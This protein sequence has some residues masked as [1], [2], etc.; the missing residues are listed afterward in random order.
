M[1]ALL[2]AVLASIM[3]LAPLAIAQN[4]PDISGSAVTIPWDDF[5]EILQKM[6]TVSPAVEPEPPV[7]YTLGRG[8]LTGKLDKESLELTTTYPL[9]VLKKGWVVCPLVG[10]SAPLADVL[11]D[12]ETAPVT[13][14][15]GMIALILKGPATHQLTMR[16]QVAA[17][18]RPGPGSVSLPL[19]P[20][21]GQVMNL[22]IGKKLAGVSIDGATMSQQGDKISAIL[23]GDN[24]TIRYTVA[25]E[26]TDEVVEVLPSKVVVENSTLVSIDEGFVRAVV[27]LAYEVRHAPVS[28]FTLRIPEG[29][30]VA[31]C[32]GASLVGWKLDEKT[33]VLIATVGFDVKGAYNLTVVLERSTKQES[34]TFPLPGVE[35][36]NV[37]R[38]RGFFAVQV[39]GGVEVTPGQQIQGL[40]MVDAKELPTG[41][42]DGA[43]NPL[44]LSFKYLRHPFQADLKVVRHETQPVLGAAIDSANYVMQVTEDGDCVT[45]AVYTVRNNRKQ[46]LQLT[47]PDQEK[48]A[49]WSSF[50]AGKPVR[51]SKTKEGKILL[52]LEKSS[53]T[54]SELASFEVEIIYYSNLG[55]EFGSLGSID[56]ALPIVDLPVSRSML[57]V[58]APTRFSYKRSD[59]S[60][61]ER[62]VAPSPLK[63]PSFGCFQSLGGVYVED[64]MDRDEEYKYKASSMTEPAAIA[65][66]S[67]E[68]GEM[69]VQQAEAEQVFRQQIRK[70]QQ[71]QDTSGALPAKFSVPQ[72]GTALRFFEL[73]SIGESSTLKLCYFTRS[74]DRAIALLALLITIALAWFSDRLLSTREGRRTGQRLFVLGAL[75]IV[76]LVA[77]GAPIAYVV[78]GAFF[79]LAARVVRWLARKFV[80]K[81]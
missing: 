14:N 65:S 43:T 27:Q 79:G 76:A 38:E 52:P 63:I 56:L 44:V 73:I 19:P 37:E 41:L 3:L 57:T 25:V 13:D 2:I 49:L 31:D 12:N 34:F 35:A 11:I 1:R 54:G 61:R 51:P 55:Q 78:H 24:L 40:Q 6:Q 66:I 20:A 70:A 46:F 81:R 74:F 67:R 36:Q 29:F 33:R 30:D 21:A 8:T 45:R 9:T 58:F 10:T 68:M 71:V 48:T 77:L 42:R 15:Q 75:A 22:T 39:T 28:E 50:V 5:K 16:F 23:T 59:G 53:Y 17:P 69:E 64:R 18:M 80:G 62:Y 60:M 72:E 26:R 47:L 32:T 7:P 4:L